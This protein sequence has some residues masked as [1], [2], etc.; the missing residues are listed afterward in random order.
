MHNSSNVPTELDSAATEGQGAGRD[1]ADFL[2]GRRY[3]KYVRLV[4]AALGSIPWIGGFIAAGAALH[5]EVEQGR[6]NELSKRWLEEHQDK[7]NELNEDLTQM[8]L[9]VS[10]LQS[11][12]LEYQ[13]Q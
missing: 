6:V 2:K 10:V 12:P 7:L 4:F 1:L 9:G 11:Q 13:S 8:M 3:A 5:A